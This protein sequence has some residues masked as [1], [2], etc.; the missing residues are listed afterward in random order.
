MHWIAP[1]VREL[2]APMVHPRPLAPET[3]ALNLNESPIGPSPSAIA[4]AQATIAGVNRYPPTDGGALVKAL[5]ARTGI[6]ADR[7][8]VSV[9]SDMMLHLLCMVSLA[10]GRS[11]VLPFP[12]F[13]RYGIS[14]RIAGAR[15]IPVEVTPD[16]ANDPERLLA[17]VAPDTSIVFCCTPNGNTGGVLTRAA[18]RQIAAHVPDDV[19]L[20]VDEAYAEF[21]PEADTLAVLAERRGPW[22]V[23]RTFSKAYALAGLRVGYALC[24]DSA[25]AE[26]LRAVRPIFE[27]TSPAL[28]AAEAA[29]GDAAH[30]R[31]MLDLVSHGR[32]QLTQGLQALG[33]APLPSSA[34]FVT[35]DLRRQAGPVLREMERHGVLVRGVMDPGYENFLRITVGLPEQNARALAVLASS[36][37][38]AHD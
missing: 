3:L 15:A 5:S 4:A 35:T 17:A 22:V 37:A 11:A 27:M 20:V 24:S 36:L 26:T 8:G 14:T 9:G 25:V 2:K 32:T 10:P 21:D 18:L 38:A 19:M 6:P 7:I 28:A 29:L 33:F 23:T 16:G 12:S 34:N 31:M 1:L 30:L 13:P